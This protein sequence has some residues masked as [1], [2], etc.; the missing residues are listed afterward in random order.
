MSARGLLR[1]DT[2]NQTNMKQ[3]II[4]KFLFTIASLL[5]LVATV[6]AQDALP[7]SGA[8]GL[9]GQTY[10]GLNYT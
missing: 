7:A 4:T 3:K 10:A 8:T 5:G 1:E 6:R 9:L 2:T